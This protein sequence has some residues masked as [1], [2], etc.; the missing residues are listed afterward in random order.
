MTPVP[1]DTTLDEICFVARRV[2]TMLGDARSNAD[3][4]ARLVETVP[5]LADLLVATANDLLGDRG[6]AASVAHAVALLGFNRVESLVRRYLYREIDRLSMRRAGFGAA[7]TERL[8]DARSRLR[9]TAV[10]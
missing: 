8:D 9:Y 10:S 1:V 2:L 6:E 4:V 5:G 3:R 7:E